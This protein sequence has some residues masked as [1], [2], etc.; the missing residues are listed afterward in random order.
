MWR[1]KDVRSCRCRECRC[2]TF[3]NVGEMRMSRVV[4]VG[5]FE[6]SRAV[7]V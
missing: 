3:R 4:A 5:E 7:D 1:I 6:M 2:G